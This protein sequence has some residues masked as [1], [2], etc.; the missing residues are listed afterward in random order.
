VADPSPREKDEEPEQLDSLLADV[1]EHEWETS[2][3]LKAWDARQ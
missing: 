1:D 3:V 2:L